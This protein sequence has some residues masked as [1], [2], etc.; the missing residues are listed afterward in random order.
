MPSPFGHA[1]AGLIV[2]LAGDKPR[3][4]G[5]A[6]PRT[7]PWA[8]L[9]SCM[10]LAALPDIDWIHPPWHRGPTH[11]IGA[12]A[13]ITLAAAGV[14]RLATGRTRWRD[15]LLCGLAYASHIFMDW[16]GE[17]PTLNPGVAAL[18]PL[19]DQ[20]FISGLNLFRS[21]RRLE[22]LA[23]EQI[24]HNF[25]TLVQE[26]LILGPILI[27]LLLRRKKRSTAAGSASDSASTEV[28]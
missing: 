14:T 9:L 10:F 11:S 24:L 19:S 27:W 23:P 21:T 28:R 2:A 16:L 15:A 8:L 4:Y 22:V 26:I 18:W 25:I 1:L 5:P 17:D 6:D 3:T 12:V 20:M 13:I 7:F